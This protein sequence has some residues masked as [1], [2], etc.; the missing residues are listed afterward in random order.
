MVVLRGDLIK[1]VVVGDPAVGK[2]SL[3]MNY[4]TNRF[5]SQ[6]VPAVFDNYAGSLD[7]S[8][9][10]Y[11]LHLIDTTEQGGSK[12]LEYSYPGTDVFVVCFSV[13]KPETF[14]HMHEHWIPDIQARMGDT[15]F[16]VVGTQADLRDDP[17]VLRTLQ[18][19]GQSPVRQRDAA[20]LC[21]KVGSVCYFETSTEMKKRLR[22]V[23]ND[24]FVSVFCPKAEFNIGCCLQPPNF[25]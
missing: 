8:R 1:C 2:T 14:T 6:H 18:V 5:P 19:K 15:P 9:R 13:V 21:R 7:L 12:S 17:E 10:R 24:A 23:M 25:P 3:L 11:N 16:I 22:R 4:A 20:S